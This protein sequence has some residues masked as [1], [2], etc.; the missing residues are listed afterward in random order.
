MTEIVH[1]GSDNGVQ[2]EGNKDRA[3]ITF[4]PKPYGVILTGDRSELR[5]HHRSRPPAQ[6]TGLENQAEKPFLVGLSVT[7]VS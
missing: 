6:P 4:G 5:S 2:V 3:T 7:N 1:L